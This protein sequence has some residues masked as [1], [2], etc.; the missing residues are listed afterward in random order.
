MIIKLIINVVMGILNIFFNILPNQNN[1]NLIALYMNSLQT[2]IA[3]CTQG[4]NFV[5]FLIGDSIY[6]ILPS[7]VALLT[8][9]FILLP[10]LDFIR[11]LIPFVNL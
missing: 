9:K 5:H 3:L 10:I 1:D 4:V 8:L 7:A 2:L 6:I 11:R